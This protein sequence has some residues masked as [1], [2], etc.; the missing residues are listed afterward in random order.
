MTS[1]STL[2]KRKY[3]RIC[4]C[5]CGERTGS[6]RAEYIRSHRP[7]RPLAERLWSRVTRTD[8]CWTWDGYT[9]DAGYGQI[10][11]G[12]KSE[13]LALTHRVAWETTHGAIPTGLGVLHR[14]DNP[15][16]VRPDHLFLGT[17]ADN[18]QDMA[19][20]GRGGSAKGPAHSNARLTTVEVEQIRDLD[21]AGCDRKWIAQQYAITPQHVGA[22]ARRDSRKDG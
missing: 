20:K 16:C 8:D 12:L 5:G 19:A 14:C 10:G 4:A 3:N 6:P 22:I 11:R 18:S 2:M 13:G 9:T 7:L 17:P 15:P 1:L 21:A